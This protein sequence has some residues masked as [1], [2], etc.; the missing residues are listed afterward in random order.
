MCRDFKNLDQKFNL[1]RISVGNSYISR[2]SDGR[3]FEGKV[4]KVKPS[5]ENT[6]VTIWKTGD[7]GDWTDVNYFIFEIFGDNGY[8]G[9]ITLEFYKKGLRTS[10]KVVLQSGEVAETEKE[11]PGYHVSGDKSF[12]K[13]SGFSV[14]T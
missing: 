1:T 10:E 3:G 9:V 7:N 13:T 14:A 4:L 6:S 5:G 12:I 8:S 11:S 2:I